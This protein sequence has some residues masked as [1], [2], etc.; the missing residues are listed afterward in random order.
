MKE[1][2]SQVIKSSTM[3]QCLNVTGKLKTERHSM[4]YPGNIFYSPETT[5]KIKSPFWKDISFTH[6]ISK[7]TWKK[8]QDSKL[9][10]LLCSLLSTQ[11]KDDKLLKI[12]YELYFKTSTIKLCWNGCLIACQIQ[13]YNDSWW[14]SFFERKVKKRLQHP[15]SGLLMNVI[16]NF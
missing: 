15:G 4:F 5:H 3:C 9:E 7:W 12:K 10:L 8:M 13:S 1:T 6:T 11:V 16:I 2:S 14:F